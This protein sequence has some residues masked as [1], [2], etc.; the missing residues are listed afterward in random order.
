MPTA[1][2]EPIRTAGELIDRLGGN[3]IVSEHLGI[4]LG[5]VYNA[6]AKNRIHEHWKWRLSK[7]CR[8]KGVN[9]YEAIFDA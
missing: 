6:R 7:L 3:R 8:E 2:A 5:A 1:E 9:G 4:V